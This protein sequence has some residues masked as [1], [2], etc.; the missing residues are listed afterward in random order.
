MKSDIFAD[1]E[2]YYDRM[3]RISIPR[4]IPEAFYIALKE[5]AVV[6]WVFT[7]Q[8]NARFI[9]TGRSVGIGI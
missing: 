2:P 9:R 1:F 5:I 3:A 4:P 8:R 7:P 6:R